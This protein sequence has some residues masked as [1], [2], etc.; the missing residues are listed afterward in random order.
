MTIRNSAPLALAVLL[1][2]GCAAGPAPIEPAPSDPAPDPTVTSAPPVNDDPTSW[3]V[4]YE[5]VGPVLWGSSADDARA[6]LLDFAE[7]PVEQCPA[8][9]VFESETLPNVWLVL[10]DDGTTVD[11]V[12]VTADSAGDIVSSPETAEG[13]GVGS[14]VDEVVAAYP[15]AEVAEVPV[16]DTRY[17]VTDETGWINIVV[18]DGV[19]HEIV[20]RDEPAVSYEVCG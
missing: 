1:L 20:V 5:G 4:G 12:V 11:Q 15:D 10:G 14:S 16:A 8:L 9:V 2:A 7:K 19:V 6:S 17:S 3:I 13:I 18:R